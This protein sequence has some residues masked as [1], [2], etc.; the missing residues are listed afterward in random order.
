MS[1]SHSHSHGDFTAPPLA[2]ALAL[3]LLVVV[4][5]LTAWGL[6]VLWPDGD[7]VASAAEQMPA[8]A[9]DASFERGEILHI[10]E[11]CPSTEPIRESGTEGHDR[12]TTDSV[13]PGADAAGTEQLAPARCM[14][15]SVGLRSGPDSGQMVT[16]HVRGALAS[17][18]LRPGDEVELIAS[19]TMGPGGPYELHR[20][21]AV[22]GIDRGL[23]LSVLALV[24]VAVVLAVGRLR[25]ALALV[26]LAVSAWVLLA[27]VLPALVAGGPGLLIGLVASSAI[28]FPILYLVHGPNMRTTAALIGTLCGILIMAGVSTIAIA[29]TRLSGI[30]DEAAGTLSGVA[31]TIDFR[32]M[33]SCAI[34]IAGLGILND[35]T[36]T[37]AS[38]VWELRSAAPTMPRR[39]L[40]SRAMRIGRD[41][42]ASTVYTVFFAYVGAALG[43]LI[44]LSLYDRPMLSLLT[45]EDLATEVV[46]TLCG[47]IGLVLA[48][49]I[50][51]AV[52]ALFAPP[53]VGP[54]PSEWAPP[55]RQH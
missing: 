44:L 22:A 55:L 19:P 1:H 20:A 43:V 9:A 50:T 32:G 18:G 36:I 12:S 15:L 48:V 52:A 40:Y 29:T 13:P 11:H 38:S 37:Q 5:V 31:S 49:P 54:V 53:A 42:I 47:S 7:R 17:S 41:H 34:V 4:A 30:G 8:A 10:H 26:A 3:G 23:A 27:F 25:G 2:R 16:L 28:M 24:C 6:I 45:Y 46:R 14:T 35:V 21:Y 33:L 51:T 39:E